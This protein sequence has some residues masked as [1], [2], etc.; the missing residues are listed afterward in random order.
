M[1]NQRSRLSGNM[2]SFVKGE[3]RVMT[4]ETVCCPCLIEYYT[5][6]GR[7]S[8]FIYFSLNIVINFVW[9][10]KFGLNAFTIR[11]DH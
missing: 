4:S 1:C 2:G 8:N 10:G 7:G 5:S 3:L 9:L 11:S 6:P